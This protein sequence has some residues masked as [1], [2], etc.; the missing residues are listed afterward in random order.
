MYFSARKK[1]KGASS[2][3][4]L[5]LTGGEAKKIYSIDGFGTLVDVTPDG[6]HLLFKRLPS[7]NDNTLEVVDSASGKAAKLYPAKGPATIN[8]AKF[9]AD[10]TRVFVSTDTGGDRAVLLA[11]DATSGKEL[12][13]YTDPASATASVLDFV[14]PVTR[15][16]LACVIEAGNHNEIRLLDVAT[17]KSVA[18]VKLPL[19]SGSVTDFSDD[20][21]SVVV[22]WSTPNTPTDLF[23]VDARSGEVAPLR[24][25]LR[26]TI[27]DLP[28]LEVSV[29][30]VAAHDGL[31]IPVHE[32][33]PAAA[34]TGRSA[35]APARASSSRW[36][37][38]GS[39]QTCV[40]RPDSGATTRWPTTVSSGG[41][42]SRTS[43]PPESGS[44]RS[45]GPTRIV[46]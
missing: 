25:E 5:P 13:R 41:R 44:R 31:K 34:K 39:S 42:R 28:P 29:G 22:A 3:Y 40:A 17:L 36:D 30:E 14:M 21:K 27:T 26:P 15:D 43:K 8:D 46:S 20:G 16:K 19:G 11:L 45:L 2:V 18:D 1:E 6:G 7:H 4:A 10:G 33:L 38:L 35:G 32:F 12:A 24:K 23:L 37:T 9:S